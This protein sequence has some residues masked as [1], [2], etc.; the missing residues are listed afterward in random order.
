MS[1]NLVW[2]P[3][4]Q[5]KFYFLGVRND[6]D[7]IIH[8]NFSKME[9]AE[10]YYNDEGMENIY[11]VCEMEKKYFFAGDFEEN[12]DFIYSKLM[13]RIVND[14]I[15]IFYNKK[16]KKVVYGKLL[17]NDMRHPLVGLPIS[18]YNDQFIGIVEAKDLKDVIS[19]MIK[20]KINVSKS[21][22][23]VNQNITD[24]HNQILQFYKV[25]F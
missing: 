8:L 13:T 24:G 7:S 20:S 11:K 17:R 18:N 23:N 6:L 12:S 21:L 15:S 4:F 2:T 22:L 16:N 5:N 9:I 19:K 3:K 1:R 10:E 25:R 14:E